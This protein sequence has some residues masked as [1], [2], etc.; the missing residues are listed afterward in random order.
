MKL[1]QALFALYA[2]LVFIVTLLIFFP[3][4]IFVFLFFDD[5]KA[6]RI[7]HRASNVWAKILFIAFLIRYKI[8]NK[9]IIDRNKAYIFVANHRSFLDIPLFAL[10]CKNTFRFLAKAELTKIPLLGYVIKKLY[11]TVKRGDKTDRHRSMDAM[12]NSLD[13]NVSVFVCPEG[14]R[15]KTDKPLLDFKDGA[16]R[17][18]IATKTPLAV[19]AIWNTEK[20][21]SPKA[22]YLL[23]PGKVFGRWV[24]VIDTSAMNDGDLNLLKER[25]KKK[26]EEVLVTKL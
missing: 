1:L 8:S 12:K 20:L 6:P 9:E 24:D 23:K 21:Y 15:N 17:L 4:Y 19:L 2:L 11:I 3:V 5:K 26:M 14:T 18:A 16:F 10:S 22:T 25:V 13:E 7:A